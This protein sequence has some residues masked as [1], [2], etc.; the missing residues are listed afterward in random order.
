MY[1]EWCGKDI[2]NGRYYSIKYQIGTGIFSSGKIKRFGI[3]CSLA[4]CE[5]AQRTADRYEDNG[6]YIRAHFTEHND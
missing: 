1:C 3:F 5:T 6:A 4:C 2:I